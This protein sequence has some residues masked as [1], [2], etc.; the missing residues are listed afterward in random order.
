MVEHQNNESKNV[1][2]NS[3]VKPNEEPRHLITDENFQQLKELQQRIYECTE[4]SPS[5]RKLIN[6]IIT[7]EN[8]NN[9]EQSLLNQLT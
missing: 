3:Q 1:S 8:L 4:M 5:V 9:V 2:E 6:L 7:Q